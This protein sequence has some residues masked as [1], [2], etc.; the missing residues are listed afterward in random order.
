M[1]TAIPKTRSELLRALARASFRTFSIADVQ[2]K[3]EVNAVSK[4]LTKLALARK[5]ACVVI[6]L[7]AD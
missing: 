2:T 5:T 7:D 1:L 6:L 3:E 4:T